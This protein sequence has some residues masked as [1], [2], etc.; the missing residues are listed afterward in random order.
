MIDFVTQITPVLSEFVEF[1]LGL[2]EIGMFESYQGLCLFD[3]KWCWL[4]NRTLEEGELLTI[5]VIWWLE[6]S[7]YQAQ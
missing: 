7:S 1:I 4:C 2:Y 6:T 5:G 3:K